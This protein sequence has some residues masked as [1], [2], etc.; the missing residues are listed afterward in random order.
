MGDGSVE[1][2]YGTTIAGITAVTGSHLTVNHNYVSG[3]H[4]NECKAA[5]ARRWRKASG[6]K[7]TAR[8]RADRRRDMANR[9]ELQPERFRSADGVIVDIDT[10]IIYGKHWIPVG[11]M[12]RDGYIVVDRRMTT[13]R[14]NVGA[15]R[16]VW[17]SVNG[18][19]PHGMEINHLNGDK[20]D[21][22]LS[23]LEMTD[24]SGNLK[25]AY[26]NGLASNRGERHPRRKL[27][28]SAVRSIRAAA[29]KNIL[30]RIL[31][32]QFGVS[33]RCITDVV[34]GKTWTHVKGRN[35]N[36]NS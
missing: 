27:D 21:N 17:Q 23:N 20:S 14:K 13:S 35:S 15:H 26:A 4:C 1:N 33:R 18:H 19:I 30:P 7:P 36:A 6:G 31:A 5:Y 25:H 9:A 3:I 28:D 24:R 2:R 12:S 29:A 11:S 8:K 10:G 16:L 22:R 34:N 32:S